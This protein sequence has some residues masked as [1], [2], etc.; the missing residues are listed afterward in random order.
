MKK[1]NPVA[2]ITWF[3]IHCFMF[4]VISVVTKILIK[5][6]INIF[7]IVFFQTLIGALIL[8]PIVLLRHIE[9]IKVISY[10][11]HLPRAIAWALATV[12]FFNA[13]SV[14]S[15]GRAIAISF[16][17][18]LFTAILAVIFLNEKLQ[19]RRIIAL[20][21]GFIGMLIIIRPRYDSFEIEAYMVVLAAFLWSTTDVM[22]KISAK[23][24]HV[25]VNTFY[26]ALFSAIC[27]LPIA[28]F[29][30]K[31][32]NYNE[33]LWLVLLAALFVINI[34][35]ITK[36]YEYA[37]LTIIMPFVFTEL[38]FVAVLAY[39][40]FGEVI[41]LPTATGSAIIIIS[42]TYMAYKERSKNHR[43][44]EDQLAFKLASELGEK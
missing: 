34:V 18:P 41:D 11:S 37:D 9:S 12:L 24:H 31:T 8:L 36:S 16:V 35:C 38:I 42:T 21:C 44:I 14:I 32:P 17:V 22:I 25:F 1:N 27:T 33:I 23:T 30:W 5:D 43:T 6:G 29:V 13:A 26:F 3:I 20:I 28:L 15:M 10:R 19:S 40:I 4:A 7:E 2:G 39:I